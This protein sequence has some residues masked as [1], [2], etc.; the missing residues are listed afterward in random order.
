MDYHL[1]DS[2]V[3]SRSDP[4][5]AAIKHSRR[6]SEAET[7]GLFLYKENYSDYEFRSLENEFQFDPH[8]FSIKNKDFYPHLF[9][10]NII[11]LFHSHPHCSEHLSDLDIEVSRSLGLPSLVYS[12]QTKEFNLYYPESYKPRPLI[13]RV[14]IPF[15]QDCV[16]FVK[17]YYKLELGI[18]LCAF[19]SCWARKK[20]NPNKALLSVI[21]EHF[22]E[23][24]NS[25]LLKGDLLVFHPQDTRLFH[26]AVYHEN[27]K[28]FHHPLSGLPRKELFTP[29]LMNKVYKIYRYKDL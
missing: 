25:T 29:T 20:H 6:N 28:I 22:N 17:D 14:F 23:V 9:S 5:F 27:H 7:C 11:C 8:F 13:G 3:H 16:I 24:N 26:L 2:L 1:E 18:D 19:I 15:F 10:N 4:L 12:L 21:N